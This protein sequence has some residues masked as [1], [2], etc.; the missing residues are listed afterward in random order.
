MF[1]L[2]TSFEHLNLIVDTLRDQ[3]RATVLQ[4]LPAVGN[5]TQNYPFSEGVSREKYW[6]ME[7]F[8]SSGVVGK[9]SQSDNIVNLFCIPVL[10]AV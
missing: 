2:D 4:L 6:I 3:H 9:V 10:Y 5:N 7:N 1:T 8:F